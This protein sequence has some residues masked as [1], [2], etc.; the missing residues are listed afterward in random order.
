MDCLDRTNVVQSMLARWTLN[1]QLT[2]AGV[3]VKEESITSFNNFEV[4]FR[5][6]EPQSCDLWQVTFLKR[7]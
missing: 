3:L 6:G 4:M 5:N 1:R 2:D 7:N